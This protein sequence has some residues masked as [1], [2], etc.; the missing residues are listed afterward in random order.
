MNGYGK[1]NAGSNFGCVKFQP[2]KE[3]ESILVFGNGKITYNPQMQKRNGGGADRAKY[4]VN[5]DIHTECYSNSLHGKF[6]KHISE[7]RYPSSIQKFN[8]ERGLHPTQKPV[9]LLEYLIKTYSKEGDLVLDNTMESGST[10]VACVNTN[11]KFIG[12]EL[13]EKY[14]NIAKQRIDKAFIEKESKLF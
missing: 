3:H 5:F 6:T 10:G 14:F 2:M 4:D 7:L 13:E 12:I 11:R 1:K 9:A 8:R